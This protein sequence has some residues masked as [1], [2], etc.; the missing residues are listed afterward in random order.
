MPNE[1]SQP[2]HSRSRQPGGNQ[3]ETRRPIHVPAFGRKE[4]PS[5]EVFEDEIGQQPQSGRQPGPSAGG[6]VQGKP[7][8]GGKAFGMSAPR[9]SKLDGLAE[10]GGQGARSLLAEFRQAM[11]KS[12]A[13]RSRSGVER[14]IGRDEEP[15]IGGR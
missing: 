9:S 7:A 10:R 3:D 5:P 2:D 6:Q 4:G 12:S 1:F 13:D 14:N 8:H 11:Q 15:E